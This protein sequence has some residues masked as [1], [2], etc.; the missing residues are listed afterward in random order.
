[1]K[2]IVLE[3]EDSHYQTLLDVI[4]ALSNNHYCRVLEDEN[5]TLTKEE[6]QQ[7]Q[8]NIKK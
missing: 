5:D 1:M 2:T 8:N 4:K 7:I 6:Y 3:V